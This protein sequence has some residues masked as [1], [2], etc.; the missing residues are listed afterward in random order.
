MDAF[1][2]AYIEA[3]LWSN[4]GEHESPLGE[5]ANITQISEELNKIIAFECKA[6]QDKYGHLF[7]GEEHRAGHDFAL[8]RNGHGAGF[9]ETDRWQKDVGEQL[10]QAS[11]EFGESEVYFGD[12]TLIYSVPN[13][14]EN[15]PA[16]GMWSD[17]YLPFLDAPIN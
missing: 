8:T 16:Y 11:K 12:D 2:K 4:S 6:F 17:K 7:K 1:T 9:W 3:L 13:F 15:A 14:N 10:T 5:D